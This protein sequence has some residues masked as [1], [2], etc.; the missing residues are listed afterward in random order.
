MGKE[1]DEYSEKTL[2]L[3]MRLS[4]KPEFSNATSPHEEIIAKTLS[5]TSWGNWLRIRIYRHLAQAVI[6]GS[7]GLCQKTTCK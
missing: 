4:K 7:E 2:L 3:E 1:F 5:M 6:A